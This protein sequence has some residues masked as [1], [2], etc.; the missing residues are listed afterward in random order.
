MSAHPI[1]A[2]NIRAIVED[3]KTPSNPK[4][5]PAV[6]PNDE[7]EKDR[8][9]QL[10]TLIGLSEKF[11]DSLSNVFAKDIAEGIK[12]DVSH[13][14]RIVFLTCFALNALQRILLL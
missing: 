3:R 2:D 6:S 10:N 9:R 8:A 12:S 14:I 13:V 4:D 1:D 5:Q 11:G 7:K